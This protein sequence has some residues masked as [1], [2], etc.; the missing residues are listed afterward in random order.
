MTRLPCRPLAALFTCC[1]LA[2]CSE[3]PAIVIDDA[4]SQ[5]D[6]GSNAGDAGSGS[7]F[8]VIAS[9][10]LDF[11][12]GD[13]GG[14]AAASK[15]LTLSNQG[16][17]ALT[18][19]AA[20]SGEAFTLDAASGTVAAGAQ[21]T[22]TITPPAISGSA[23]AG[24]LHTGTLT[25][26]TN[27][28]AHASV[29][30]PLKVTASGGTLTLSPSTAT[31]G[32]IPVG[33]AAPTV[34]L[35]L[36]NTG[37]AAVSV[38]VAAP[39]D[40]QFGV[41]WTGAPSATSV[42]PG[43]S[44]SGLKASFTP[45]GIA[46]G[47]T[48]AA[49]QVT[50]ALC[51]GAAPSLRLTG[52][53]ASG[54][55][56]LPTDVSFGAGGLVPCG[57]QANALS[58]TITNS[59]NAPFSW[60][61][62]LA[63]GLASP[64]TVTPQSGTVPANGGQ[65][66]LTL[67]T[68]A[69]PA[70]APTSLD[71]FGDV[72]TVSTDVPGD[73]PHAVTLHQ[74]AQ[75]A[76]LS[77]SPGTVDFGGV[78]VN[79]T[80]SAPFS[81]VNTG[82]GDA[83]VAFSLTNAKFSATPAGPTLVAAGQSLSATATFAPGLSVTQASDTATPTVSSGDVLCA[84][85]PSALTLSG[86]GTNGSVSYSPVALDFGKVNCGSTAAPKNVVFTNS[87][88]Q[89]YTVSASL[90][91]DGG[92]PF[93]FAMNPASGLVAAQGGTLTVTVTPKAI[94]QTTPTTDNLF[95]DTL[96]VSSTVAGD[97]PHLI[98]LRQ[99]AQGSIFSVSTGSI[100]FGTVVVGQTGGFQYSVT[101]SGNAAG[102]L[103]FQPTNA[104]FTMPSALVVAGGTSS[105][106]TAQFAP[107]AAQPYSDTATVS[108]PS[109]VLCQPLPLTSMSLSGTGTTASLVAVSASSLTFGANGLVDCGTT[110]AAKTVAVTSSA[111]SS[112]S[113]AYTLAGGAASPYTVSG[114]AT[115]A[116]GATVTVTVTP[117]AIP[118]T[119]SVAPDAFADTL[120]IAATNATVN[121]THTVAL[122]ETAQ[123]AILSFNPTSLAF[124]AHP[125]QSQSKSFVVS[126]AGNLSAA[127]TLTVGGTNANNFSVT[128]TSGTA[129]AGGGATETATFSPPLA[130]GLGSRSASV[131]LST[132]AVRCAPLPS[133]LGLSG[134][135][136]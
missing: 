46:P 92:S 27:D 95:G 35:T 5:E 34:D 86:I 54:V 126:N 62:Q 3:P 12:P 39:A 78:P 13:C 11:G 88:N 94:P 75:G 63:R 89:D 58:F 7:P 33:T 56:A 133:A 48:S 17:G 85:L 98:P 66:T 109:T 32:I 82:T 105:S 115:V 128:P 116:A 65:A 111:A 16:S 117:K 122:H 114:P 42:A 36:T 2:A 41:S 76:V 23:A 73:S 57:T 81:L 108:A 118:S 59:G 21:A 130:Q 74:T 107:T 25:V 31:F 20:V 134:T 97:S 29:S 24:S 43:A 121:E 91:L 68:T 96:S 47:D 77:F 71:F 110:A 124:T 26:S 132:S 113:L 30:V 87:G 51:G 14:L 6:G 84:P 123:G 112:M 131:A 9:G 120:T 106:P 136:N 67:T 15:T 90:G 93:T 127:Y 80:A 18:W 99:T 104:V 22:L 37:N 100:A 1:F 129:S 38:V 8:A 50:G 40:A 72:F 53:G 52:R 135:A 101:N 55:V 28:E 103:K 69:I 44:L 70:T 83:H 79:T 10:A 61:G 60:T 45:T 19:T 119:S 125:A 49:V 64:F 4:G 102:T